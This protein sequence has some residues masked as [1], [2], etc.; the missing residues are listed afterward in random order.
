MHMGMQTEF[1]IPGVQH[2]EET[3]F[4]AEVSGIPRFQRIH[5]RFR[6]IKAAPVLRMR[7]ATSKGGRL[8]YSSCGGSLFSG[9]ESRGLAV[10]FR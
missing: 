9:N 10:A 2:A 4:C 6:S 7:S 5:W 3:N 8:I 1:L